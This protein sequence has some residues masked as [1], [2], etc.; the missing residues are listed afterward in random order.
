LEGVVR[1]LFLILALFQFTVTVVLSS[2]SLG[3]EWMFR[4]KPRG[5]LRVVDLYFPSNSARF[6]YSEG[7]LGVD[8]DN[9]FVP[10]LAADLR[11]ID[12]RTIEFELRHG[13]TFHNGE[14]FDAEAVRVNWEAYRGM[15]APF[16]MRLPIIPDEAKLQIIDEYTVRFILPGPDGLALVKFSWFCLFTPAFFSGHSFDEHNWGYLKEAGPWGTGPFELIEGSLPF[17]RPSNQLVLEAYEGYWDRRYP[18]VK[19][20]IFENT[21]IGNRKEAMRLCREEEGSVDIVSHIRPLDTLKVAESPFAK[22]VKSRD[23]GLLWG[24]FNQRKK[25]SKW[26][27][28]GAADKAAIQLVRVQPYQLPVSDT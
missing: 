3:Q 16:T 4:V 21:L 11:W 27:D 8:K 2:P 6:N 17:G 10:H 28:M 23:I 7:L 20:V 13:V 24:V 15:K 22:V 25:D 5:I 19:R 1:K 9:N 18:K 14:K 12:D 26:R